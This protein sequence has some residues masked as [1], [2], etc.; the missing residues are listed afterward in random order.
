MS[1][2]LTTSGLAQ[3]LVGKT[4]MRRIPFPVESYVHPSTALV[5]THLVNLF[6]E[7]E[8]SAARTSEALISSPGLYL[9]E[10]LGAGPVLAMNDDLPG[11]IYVVSGTEFYRISLGLSGV[12]VADLG[13]VG[14]PA[15]PGIAA[16]QQMPTIAVGVNAV[17]VC[18]PPHAFTVTHGGTA[19]VQLGGTF[20]G[21][22]TSVAYVDGYFAFTSTVQQFFI[23]G[24]MDPT[25]FDALDFAT[26]T[27]TPDFMNGVFSMYD[28]LWFTGYSGHEVWYDSGDVDFPFRPFPGGVISYGNASIRSVA[29]LD[30]SLF[31]IGSDDIVYRTN[32]YQAIRIST[33]GV[34]T[35]I[36]AAGV[37]TLV[38]A[39]GY[40]Q[41]G[42][43]FY[44]VNFPSLTLVYDCATK[45][46]HNRSSSTDGAARWRANCASSKV[47]DEPV[48]GDVLSGQIFLGYLGLGE[49]AGTNVIRQ[50]VMPPLWAGTNRAFMNRLEVEMDT[51]SPRIPASVFL[52]WSDDGGTTWKGGR[53]LALDSVPDGHWRVCTTR[54][55]SFRQR[56]LRLTAQGQATFYAVDAD[57]TAPAGG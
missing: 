56:I 6:A 52:E 13:P 46:W 48:F 39:F 23:C 32:G 7:Q 34:E 21:G 11:F 17:V 50:V 30:N 16:Y 18:I 36:A 19:V 44:V 45:L 54:L 51:G 4:G 41:N 49:E 43:V 29:K 26:P 31:W 33:H 14:S 12:T 3:L 27:Q 15:A 24:L 55:G 25:A 37:Y 20:P 47:G 10:T 40:S 2:A 8:P 5:S 57:I 28:Q 9:W 1:D 22:A 35:A 42:H 38:S 53:T